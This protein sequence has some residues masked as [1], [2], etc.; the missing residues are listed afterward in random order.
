MK[1]DTRDNKLVAEAVAEWR[2]LSA[3]EMRLRMG[4]LSAQD[5]RN[6]KAVLNAI[7]PR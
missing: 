6:I 5:I 3:A 2:D 4:E 7:L 1:T